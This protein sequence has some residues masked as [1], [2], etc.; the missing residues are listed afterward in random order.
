MIGENDDRSPP[1][2]RQHRSETVE[3]PLMLSSKPTGK[4]TRLVGEPASPHPM[5]GSKRETFKFSARIKSNRLIQSV[6]RE[7]D[8]CCSAAAMYGDSAA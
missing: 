6:Y 5:D 7:S 4:A 3:K 2:N 1:V 8:K